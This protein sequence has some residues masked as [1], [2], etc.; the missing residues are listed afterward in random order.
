MKK[1]GV[2]CGNVIF[3]EWTGKPV[4]GSLETLRK[5]AASG[6]FDEIHVVSK[7]NTFVRAV[8]RLRLRSLDFWDH[9]GIPRKNLHFCRRHKGKAPICKKL[10]ITDFV[11]D[12]IHVLSYLNIEGDRYAL[13]PK[14]KRDLKR[15][16]ETVESVTTVHSWEE[17]ESILLPKTSVRS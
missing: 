5:I 1:L 3:R 10:G 15:H 14:L 11:D 9:T 17:L 8:F 16:P 4:P 6:E 12:R 13:N 7:A 2:D